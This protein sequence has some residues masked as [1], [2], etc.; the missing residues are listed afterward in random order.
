MISGWNVLLSIAYPKGKK[1][2]FYDIKRSK[3][4]CLKSYELIYKR[5]IGDAKHIDADC[6]SDIEEAVSAG[7][8]FVYARCT[9]ERDIQKMSLQ[10]ANFLDHVANNTNRDMIILLNI[11]ELDYDKDALEEIFQK[12]YEKNIQLGIRVDGFLNSQDSK[13]IKGTILYSYSNYIDFL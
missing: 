13:K 2:F 6:V 8:S 11:S 9:G 3:E 4:L 1:S 5:V 10:V 7:V 12:L